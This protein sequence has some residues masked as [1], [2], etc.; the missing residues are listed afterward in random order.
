MTSWDYGNLAYLFLLGSVLVFWFVV[1]NR[2][3]LGKTV[4]QALAWGFIFIGMIAVIGVW[5]DIRDT[6]RPRQNVISDAGRVEVPRA[7][8]GHYYLTLRIN[9]APVEF[10][11]DTGASQMVLTPEDARRA[12]IDAR[13]LAFVGRAMTANGEV[14]TAPVK[15]KTVD[16][17]SISDR[18]V[19]AW[20][21]EGEMA[22][23]LLGMTYL[24][25]WDRIEITSGAL[26]LTR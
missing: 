4:Q 9:G 20:V 22:Q 1:Q 17:G 12:G 23:S 18:N 26:I 5:D 10:M 16:L 11:V 8:D 24:Q 25:R 2:N 14:R 3:S 15:L 13:D 7:N 19:R 21:N 6:I